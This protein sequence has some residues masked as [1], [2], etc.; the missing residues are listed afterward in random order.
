MDVDDCY[1]YVSGLSASICAQGFADPSFEAPTPQIGLGGGETDPMTPPLT[2]ET[3]D[4][5]SKNAK[6]K[7]N[8]I[9]LQLEIKKQHQQHQME[10]SAPG[11]VG[12]YGM[13]MHSN[14]M[15]VGG[16]Q[17][18]MQPQ[19]MM[20][21]VGHGRGQGDNSEPNDTEMAG[22][23]LLQLAMQDAGIT[24][25]TSQ[26]ASSDENV[27]SVPTQA[28]G[29]CVT[30]VNEN[31]ALET[32]AS[33]ATVPQTVGVVGSSAPVSQAAVSPLV[34]QSG[35]AMTAT[36]QAINANMPIMATGQ[37]GM[38]QIG[39]N[40]GMM[41]VPF[42]NGGQQ[43][44]PGL[45]QG[46]QAGFNA[47]ISAPQQQIVFI[48]EQ[49]MPC[50]ANVPMG[51]DPNTL[52]LPNF[53]KHVMGVDKTGNIGM[54]GFGNMMVQKDQGMSSELLTNMNLQGQQAFQQ[55]QNAVAMGTAGM[56]QQQMSLG[57]QV[58]PPMH[59]LAGGIGNQG[60]Q[61]LI[62]PVSQSGNLLI[63]PSNQNQ[64]PPGSQLPQALLLPNGQIIPVVANPQAGGGGGGIIQAG[65]NGGGGVIQTNAQWQGGSIQP[66]GAPQ[67]AIPASGGQPRM[68]MPPGMQG[69]MVGV[70]GMMGT[71]A[72]AMSSSTAQMQVRMLQCGILQI[73]L[74]SS[75]F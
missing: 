35:S 28:V 2:T 36:T 18:M 22:A 4:N 64:G 7:R 12:N 13:M 54:Q 62:M 1:Y 19:H 3:G 11:M 30:G 20:G 34:S 68:S 33:I 43:F 49:G 58:M 9:S 14:A 51:I 31:S 56:V 61:G 75:C 72:G 8:T 70:D 44:P 27:V 38:G 41:N 63:N 39:P 57:Q 37:S 42:V 73:E 23:G 50:I 21:T 26:C 40:N 29:D 74:K 46:Q 69:S 32:L 24:P 55:A 52:G 5:K 71:S 25:N 53:Q 47:G 60:Q 15:M 59:Q 17:M 45:L 67:G 10:L 65:V 6:K 66:S 16:N 48:N